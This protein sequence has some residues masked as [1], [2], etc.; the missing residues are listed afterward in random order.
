MSSWGTALA[1][2]V[3][4]SESEEGKRVRRK[5]GT[6]GFSQQLRSLFR[7][8]ATSASPGCRGFPRLRPRS[9]SAESCRGEYDHD[10]HR[11]SHA[12]TRK[13]RGNGD[14]HT[15]VDPPFSVAHVLLCPYQAF[16]LP[17]HTRQWWSR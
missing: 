9:A 14:H 6:A 15:R 16:F 12:R 3:P 10:V 2:P 13:P 11:C 1:E 17:P 4:K 8:T 5:A 7:V